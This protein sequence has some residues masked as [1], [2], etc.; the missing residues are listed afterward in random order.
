[1]CAGRAYSEAMLALLDGDVAAAEAHYRRREGFAV[2]DRPVMRAITLGARRFRRTGRPTPGGHHRTGRS[3]PPSR[4]GRHAGFVG[5]LLAPGMV[6]AARRA[7]QPGRGDDPTPSTPAGACAAAHPVLAH[8]ARQ[9]SIACPSQPGRRRP[10]HRIAAHPRHR[11]QAVSATGSTPTSRSPRCSP[12]AAPCWPSCDRRRR[13]TKGP[14]ARRAALLRE[15][16]GAPVASFHR[17]DLRRRKQR[18]PRALGP[19]LRRGLP[20]R[21]PSAVS[22]QAS[23]TEFRLL[24]GMPCPG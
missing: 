17:G 23:S 14:A 22:W 1:M 11:R 7:D 10:R 24:I 18:R 2:C 9:S 5:S 4:D 13:A 12:C 19:D 20:G 16:V 3:H 8:A 6:A 21:P 15:Q